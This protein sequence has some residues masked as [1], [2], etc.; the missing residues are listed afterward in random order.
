MALLPFFQLLQASYSFYTWPCAPVL[1]WFLW[2]NRKE[3]LGKSVLEIGSGTALPGIVAAKCGAKVTL[4]D[5]VTLP[6]SL[7]HIRRSCQLNGLKI[8]ENIKLIGLTWGL[9]LNSYDIIGPVDLILGSDC[10]YEPAVFEDIIVTVSFIL[11]L[12]PG[13]KFL[14]TYQERSSDWSIEALLRKWNL[15]C[16]VHSIANLGA[17]TGLDI[18]KLIGDHSIQLIEIH[19]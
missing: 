14:C 15:Q 16:K 4:S 3:L 7:T 13:A 17:S 2:E 8:D 12:N 5:S 18:H 9:F 11:D 6:K 10:F 1:A 19:R